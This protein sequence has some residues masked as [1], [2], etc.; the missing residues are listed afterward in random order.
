MAPASS[1][2]TGEKHTVNSTDSPMR[3]NGR[4]VLTG[5]K[6]PFSP[7]TK[8]PNVNKVFVLGSQLGIVLIRTEKQNSKDD[9]FVNNAIKMIEDIESGV[10]ARLSIIKICSRRQSQ[11]I[12]KAILQSSAYHSQWFVS[13]TE[14]TNNTETF[15]RE[16][17]DNFIQ[18]LNEIEWKWPQQFAFAGDETKVEKGT[19][20]STLD[21]YLLNVDIAAI[22]RQYV[23]DDLAN[24]LDD[25]D[26]V[27]SCFGAKCTTDQARDYLKDAWNINP[28]M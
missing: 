6:L 24:F 28:T 22:L 11:L 3:K 19:L 13:I 27:T 4:K 2:I 25:R 10:A 7:R 8:V 1:K 16:H 18:F 5:Q 14:E 26:A 17:V 21:M 15:R 20:A 23:F 9:A 12:D